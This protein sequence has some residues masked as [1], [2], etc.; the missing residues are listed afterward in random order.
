MKIEYEQ[1]ENYEP[2]RGDVFIVRGEGSNVGLHIA[3]TIEYTTK[4]TNADIFCAVQLL[5]GDMHFIP[6]NAEIIPVNAILKIN[7]TEDLNMNNRSAIPPYSR[8]WDEVVLDSSMVN[9]TDLVE[10]VVYT[11]IA[12]RMAQ[13]AGEIKVLPIQTE[14]RDPDRWYNELAFTRVKDAEDVLREKQSR[15]GL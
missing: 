13:P 11:V 1:E 10:E 2:K 4:R 7:K 3:T 15:M 6:Y 14:Y 12:V 9:T 5:T 8:V